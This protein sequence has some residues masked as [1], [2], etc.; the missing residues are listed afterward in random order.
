MMASKC[1]PV[2]YI[3]QRQYNDTIVV[4]NK[5]FKERLNRAKNLYRK[6]LLGHYGCVNAI[7]FSD[8]GE[9]LI[10]GG[11]DRR[12][13]LWSVPEAIFGQG[14]AIT[15]ET[16]HFSNIFCLSFDST[17]SK[18]FSGG[19][20]DQVLV[21]DSKTG[22]IV[23]KLP[24]VK[25]VYGL[26]VNPECNSVLATAGDDGR[27]LICDI[28]EPNGDSLILAKQK[29]GFHSVKYNPLNSRL[30]VTANS[31]EG[32]ALWDA[33]KPREVYIHYDGQA[34]PVSGI[35][36]CFNADG[37]RIL[38]LRRRLPPALYASHAAASLCQFYHPHYYNSCTM[39][40]CAFA[41]DSDEYVLSGSDDFNLYMWKIPEE[42]VDWGT[43]HLVLNG[44]RSIVN[45]VRYNRQCNLI[46]SSGVEKMVKLWSTLP[47][48][49]WSGSLQ[50]PYS[51]TDRPVYSHDEYIYL[52][53]GSNTAP[54]SQQLTA[55]QQSMHNQGSGQQQQQQQQ[56][57]QQQRITHD[58]SE[59]STQ[60]DAR[61]MAF[62]DS[63][64]QREIEGWES[65]SEDTFTSDSD[66]DTLIQE[67]IRLSWQSLLRG[68]KQAEENT[69]KH[70]PN[71]IAQL[72]AQKRNRLAKMAHCK[73]KILVQRLST[74]D[75]HKKRAS[76]RIHKFRPKDARHSSKYTSSTRHQHGTS[77]GVGTSANQSSSSASG[78]AAS[79]T[80]STNNN[81]NNNSHNKRSNYLTFSL[82]Q[83]QTMSRETQRERQLLEMLEGMTEESG[84]GTSSEKENTAVE[85][86][87]TSYSVGSGGRK[88]LKR[89]VGGETA[90]RSLKEEHGSN[91][92]HQAQ[93]II[94][95]PSTSTGITSSSS[96]HVTFSQRPTAH[97]SS[98][99]IYDDSDDD[100]ISPSCGRGLT[101]G[102]EEED[103]E[104]PGNL[105]NILPT[106]LNGTHN[107]YALNVLE[108][109][110]GTNNDNS[111]NVVSVGTNTDL[112]YSDSDTDSYEDLSYT[113]TQSNQHNQR[114]RIHKPNVS[115]ALRSK[116]KTLVNNNN[117]TIAKSSTK[118]KSSSKT[119]NIN[120]NQN[121]PT[122]SKN[123]N[124][125]TNSKKLRSSTINQ[126]RPIHIKIN[127]HNK[128]RSKV[129][130]KPSL[131]ENDILASSSNSSSSSS[132]SASSSSSSS[133]SNSSNED[134]EED[135]Q[136]ISQGN[137][138]DR[139]SVNLDDEYNEE[140]D[141]RQGVNDDLLLLSDVAEA[142]DDNE[143]SVDSD[144]DSVEALVG[145]GRDLDDDGDD[146]DV[147]TTEIR[148]RE[149]E[150]MVTP[151]K[152]NVI[153]MGQYNTNNASGYTLASSSSAS[154]RYYRKRRHSHSR[155]ST[156]NRGDDNT[157]SDNDDRTITAMN[158][159]NNRKRASNHSC[160][161]SNDNSDSSSDGDNYAAASTTPAIA[162]TSGAATSSYYQRLRKQ[163]AKKA[164]LNLRKQ[165]QVNGDS[166]S[167]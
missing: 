56:Q 5:L 47:I 79:S 71:R 13:L 159:A 38:A 84:A 167:N 112:Q 124:N 74:R 147:R 4:K 141:E 142:G 101:N 93:H 120:H 95:M 21:H 40:T 125:L 60:E 119:N 133:S 57:P 12:V 136:Q 7:E 116:G 75:K 39:K 139:N 32:I 149:E 1:N 104:E 31:E 163:R 11:D 41:G 94:D 90:E 58:Y 97:A 146:D 50:S 85:S 156:Q 86:A 114:N 122:T 144:S 98:N 43:S 128:Y 121:K 15:M 132:S 8:E 107:V 10:S 118:L 153:R 164:K 143:G 77:N 108:V 151:I 129:I 81:N 109:S 25:P 99:S 162:T 63:L 19:N 80:S 3:V 28:R 83:Q 59:H 91:S 30:L 16:R 111:T 54:P 145:N 102:Q 82:K 165:M 89:G 62:F 105:I 131:N 23:R 18:I 20:D 72:I 160:S 51:D 27:I 34:G 117:K 49:T 78:Y 22:H 123:D 14:T 137:Q 155:N 69:R 37:T 46:A 55:Q 26:S 67:K 73:S 52:V 96:H 61:M 127:N 152:R 113:P 42:D 35:S 88:R 161:S 65:R 126:T 6:D 53:G 17:N 130:G 134:D 64:I 115:P 140:N 45:Q 138:L 87:G 106:P 100:L 135:D 66:S 24:H 29:M 166:D 36:A 44:H 148:L 33:R 154:S 157:N 9:L 68:R 110:T 158:T 150:E 48:G 76:K 70:K 2:G 92:H 103:V